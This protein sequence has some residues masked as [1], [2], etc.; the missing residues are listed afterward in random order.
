MTYRL[1]TSFIALS[2]ALA[3]PA[4]ADVSAADVFQN[5]QAL[6][7]SMGATLSGDLSGGTLANPEFSVTLPQGFASLQ[8]TT[9]AVSMTD[10]DDGTVTIQYPSPMTLTISGEAKDEG[11]FAATA[12]ITHD[13]YTII[14]SGNPGD[15]SYDVN[16][17]NLQL[18]VDNITVNGAA[19]EAMEVDG[20]LNMAG[21][22]GTTKV[23]EGNL[24]EYTADMEIGETNAD[25]TFTTDNITATT[26]QTTLPMT[27]DVDASLPVGGS[28]VMN[29]SAAL[30]DGLSVV[31]NS[32][33]EGSAS[34]TVTML[35]GQQMNRQE[36]NYG[37]QEF[38]LSFDEDG[39]AMSGEG[40]DL[41]ILMNDPLIFPAD[42]EFVIGAVSMDYDF[43][44]N[45]SEDQQD[46]RV[47]TGLTDITLGD[48]IWNMIDPSGQL[49][50]DP[51]EISFDVTGLGTNGMD[52]L[53]IA[54]MMNLRTAPPIE[55]D[56]VTIEN[57][58]IAVAGA[59]ATAEGSATFDWTDMQTIPGI[60]RPE[61][62]V[63][64]NL[65]G[66]NAL[67]DRLVAM[68]LIPEEELMMPRMMMGMFATPV[69]DDH[70]KSVLEINEEGHVMANGQRLR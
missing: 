19:V 23:N 49:P 51:A 64:V 36:T 70:V 48:T 3:A 61:G 50:R 39:L 20:V 53:D 17:E 7:S 11:S 22:S 68:G 5:Q 29:L 15:V 21:F 30:R 52:L 2:T 27:S 63:T 18:V 32:T 67:M 44:I 34:S 8:V 62:E 66:A 40:R 47:A 59:E 43:P 42:L 38:E 24:I 16:A 55:V 28:D 10:N 1:A 31:M 33:G 9:D 6:Y 45:A 56:E 60:A 35:D 54:A 41:E 26:T 46:F 58:R 4:M 25:F 13:A 69:G 14:A 65:Y 57:M 37:S 12:T